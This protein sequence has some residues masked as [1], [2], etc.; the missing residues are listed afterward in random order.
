MEAYHLTPAEIWTASA[1]PAPFGPDSLGTEG[2]VHL[3][4]AED[5]LL[6]AG[7]RYY[8]DDPRPYVAL[9]VD[10]DRLTVPWRYDGDPRFPHAYGPLDRDAIVGIHEV[11]RDADGRFRALGP[12]R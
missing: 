11:R 6:A 1:P 12:A 7:D 5:E 4:H 10:L 3:T 9:L 2:F 8:R